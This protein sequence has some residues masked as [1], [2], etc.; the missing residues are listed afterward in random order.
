MAVHG[1]TTEEQQA[2][3]ELLIE[4]YRDTEQ[5]RLLKRGIALWKRTEAERT[6]FL[7]A[8]EPPTGKKM[9]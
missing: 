8:P 5:Q 2:R 7:E 1:N 4:R 6:S 3:L 9:N